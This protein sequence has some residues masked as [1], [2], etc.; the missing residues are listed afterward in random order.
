MT[1][2][3]A[4]RLTKRLRELLRRRQPTER[5]EQLTVWAQELGVRIRERRERRKTQPR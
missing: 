3:A 4:A 5:S 2:Q 1:R